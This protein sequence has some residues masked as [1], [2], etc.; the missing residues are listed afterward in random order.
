MQKLSIVDDDQQMAHMLNIAA[1]QAGYDVTEYSDVELF[2]SLTHNEDELILLDLCMP[3]I[4]GIEVIR[5]LAE[6][7]SRASLVLMSGQDESVLHS[8]M[9]LAS[10]RQLRCIATLVKPIRISKFKS[11]LKKLALDESRP[12]L[13]GGTREW[14]PSTLELANAI[15][16]E[17][18]MLHYQPQV[19]LATGR[20]LGVEALVRWAHPQR[21][22]VYPGAFITMAEKLGLISEI[23][24]LV[25]R[26]ALAQSRHWLEMG[27][28]LHTSVN[29][30]AENIGNL[31]LP[32]Q[33]VDIVTENHLAPSQLVLE[34]TESALMGD[35]NKSLE[36]LT[37]L[38]MK[39]I[40]LS[41]DDFGTGYSSLSLLHKIPFTELKIDQ[42]FVINM[43]E[44]AEAFAI[45]ETC[46]MLGHK[47]K[48]KVVAEGVETEEAL[49]ALIAMGCDAAQGYFI[50][51]PMHENQLATWIENREHEHGNLK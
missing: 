26:M 22:L 32:E 48:M 41:V 29:I 24:K 8:A 42:S 15:N 28:M 34:I 39:G 17:Q 40:P 47:L 10:S 50:A 9:A 1:S 36:I 11:L 12:V 51:P 21:G 49:K 31:A 7:H 33:L 38:R 46:V 2:L 5:S 16:N 14:Q 37:R 20:L 45:V 13:S 4:D 43:M 30:S 19:E 6:Q 27:L 23:T 44:D 25:I 35:L 3:G 18:M